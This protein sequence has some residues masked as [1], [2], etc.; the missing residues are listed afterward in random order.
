MSRK[1]TALFRKPKVFRLQKAL[2]FVLK[3]LSFSQPKHCSFE[4]LFAVLKSRL[5]MCKKPFI[6]TNL[7]LLLSK[8]TLF[9]PP[10]PISTSLN[11]LFAKNTAV[12]LMFALIL[13]CKAGASHRFK[14]L[15]AISGNTAVFHITGY[16]MNAG[17]FRK[18]TV[19]TGDLNRGRRTESRVLFGYFLHNAKS[20]NSFLLQEISRFCKPRI[21]APQLQLRTATIKTFSRE[22]RDF[23]NLESAH[24]NNNLAQTNLNPLPLRGL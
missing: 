4:Q 11:L 22:L 1:K 21:S 3:S 20:D 2:R 12:L 7:S 15:P 18:N 6:F 19:S 24:K 16:L 17:H 9:H 5:F 13:C 23:P 10:S 8:A 14:S